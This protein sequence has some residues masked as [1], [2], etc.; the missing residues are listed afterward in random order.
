MR[1]CSVTKSPR[2]RGRYFVRWFDGEGV[3]QTTRLQYV[4]GKYNRAGGKFL[5]TNLFR[6]AVGCIKS[7]SFGMI[8]KRTRADA[9]ARANERRQKALGA[10]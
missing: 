1:L 2:V 3:L 5:P 6:Q 10:C 7:D 8:E 9:D 4:N